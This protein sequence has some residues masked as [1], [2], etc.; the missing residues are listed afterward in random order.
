MRLFEFAL[1][2]T[3]I[4][5]VTVVFTLDEIYRQIPDISKPTW[6]G[7]GKYFWRENSINLQ[8]GRK[9]TRYLVWEDKF[10][11]LM[12]G[13]KSAFIVRAG[14]EKFVFTWTAKNSLVFNRP[15]GKLNFS[16]KKHKLL[17]MKMIFYTVLD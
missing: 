16:A 5:Y 15:A 2:R 6:D 12:T 4:V 17:I 3:T 7:E 10:T 11:L 9:S 8:A 14:Q 1:F 13:N